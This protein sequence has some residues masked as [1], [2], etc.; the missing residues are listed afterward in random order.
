MKQDEKQDNLTL[1]Q[2]IQ[3]RSLAFPWQPLFQRQV[4][5]FM[6][7]LFL[8]DHRKW[9]DVTGKIDVLLLLML[10]SLRPKH[11]VRGNKLHWAEAK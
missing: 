11:K 10:T 4:S 9:V 7:A 8:F 2:L 5:D 6:K 3:L 1:S